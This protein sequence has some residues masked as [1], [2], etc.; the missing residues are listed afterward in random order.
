MSDNDKKPVEYEAPAPG[1]MEVRE[2]ALA[3]AEYLRAAFRAGGAP[4]AHVRPAK[5]PVPPAMGQD[6]VIRLAHYYQ[7]R[8]GFASD[9]ALADACGVHRSQVAR[10]KRG[11]EPDVHNARLL[12]DLATVVAR[13]ADWYDAEVIPDWLYGSSPD[14]GGR[15]PIE[16]LR[17]GGLV[18]VLAAA[19]TQ[20]SGSYL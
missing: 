3:A 9:S 4:V 12:R 7:A 16:V 18:E 19:E 2:P 8:R 17:R 14:L 20:T 1:P 13:L 11:E 10:W 5:R 6:A 15:R